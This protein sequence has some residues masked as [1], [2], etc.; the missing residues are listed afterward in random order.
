VEDQVPDGKA[1][2]V[3]D[4]QETKM[5][6]EAS[7]GKEAIQRSSR[8][9]LPETACFIGSTRPN[10][11]GGDLANQGFGQRQLNGQV[12]TMAQVIPRDNLNDGSRLSN[13]TNDPEGT[14]ISSISKPLNVESY[15]AAPHPAESRSSHTSQG[16][17]NISFL[18]LP[19]RGSWMSYGHSQPP[20]ATRLSP[21]VEA[22]PLFIRQI[23]RQ[24][25][26]QPAFHY[27]DEPSM[28]DVDQVQNALS[29]DK[30]DFTKDYSYGITEEDQHGNP[31]SFDG[32]PFL[33]SYEDV[34]NYE[35]G[36][37]NKGNLWRL[38]SQPVSH[39]RESYELTYEEEY[40]HH[41]MAGD[42]DVGDS[43][44][45]YGQVE[46]QP[47]YELYNLGEQGDMQGFWRP[48]QL[49]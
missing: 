44:Q 36:D 13:M 2:T 49:Y 18:Q 34:E 38:E 48:R 16:S 3:G 43:V 8:S 7:R 30:V 40:E 17:G 6:R 45:L 35:M 28:T 42:Y 14:R 4:K 27:G 22:E 1:C 10:D 23:L 15:I 26:T 29:T 39:D 19:V 24:P 37:L 11:S 25:L 9:E 12:G 32:F 5:P 47:E 46:L 20:Q 21:L 31:G 41:E 33:K